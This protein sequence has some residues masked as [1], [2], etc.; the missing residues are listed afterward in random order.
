MS[1]IIN[2][3]LMWSKSGQPLRVFSTAC[4]RT[5]PADNRT[6]H[7][8]DRQHHCLNGDPRTMPTLSSFKLKPCTACSINKLVSR[9]FSSYPSPPEH[10]R[11]ASLRERKCAQMEHQLTA[12]RKT[13][14]VRMKQ[15][16]EDMSKYDTLKSMESMLLLRG[17]GGHL[18]DASRKERTVF[19]DRVWKMLK[20]KN[21]PLDASHYNALLNVYIDVDY[22]VDPL[23]FLETMKK[24]NVDPNRVTFQRLIYCYALMGKP[25]GA[26]KILESMREKNYPINESIFNS[27][28]YGN[29]KADRFE[30]AMSTYKL[31]TE[32]GMELSHETYKAF[33]SGY[34]CHID[35]EEVKQKFLETLEKMRSEDIDLSY[36][37]LTDI[38]VQLSLKSENPELVEKLTQ[39]CRKRAGYNQFMY[40]VIIKLIDRQKIEHAYH[41]M[42][43][44]DPTSNTEAY[45]LNGSFMVHYLVRFGTPYEK[46]VDICERM[47]SAKIN[48]W[49]F[50]KAAETAL[51]NCDRET[52]LK[53]LDLYESRSGLSRLHLAWPRICL[54]QNDDEIFGILK[55]K[56]LPFARLSPRNVK[57]TF[58]DFVWPKVQGNKMQFLK[59]CGKIGFDFEQTALTLPFELPPTDKLT[60]MDIFE[61]LHKVCDDPLKD[62]TSSLQ[63][64]GALC[65][66]Y[67]LKFTAQ[68]ARKFL[69]KIIENSPKEEALAQWTSCVEKY[70]LCICRSNMMERLIKEED[71]DSLQRVIDICSKHVSQRETLAN[72]AL[73]FLRCGK[74]K[75]VQRIFTR[76]G[77]FISDFALNRMM[78]TLL[79]AGEIDVMERLVSATKDLK[80]LNRESQ[81]RLLLQGYI[82]NNAVDKALDMWSAIQEEDLMPSLKV[83]GPLAVFL[84]ENGR[85]IP[86]EYKEEIL[87]AERSDKVQ[88]LKFEFHKSIRMN[89]I[90]EALKIK[91]ELKSMN[92]ELTLG[93]ECSIIE[94]L[95]KSEQI[96]KARGLIGDL[97]AKGRFPSPRIYQLLFQKMIAN[98]MVK[99]LDDMIDTLPAAL[100]Q[101]SW[102]TSM[103]VRA[104][105]SSSRED[106]E[107]CLKILPEFKP[108][109]VSALLTVLE[110]RPDAEKAIFEC[111][112]GMSSQSE[113]TLPK[114]IKWIHLMKRG[115]YSKAK[116]LFE[117]VPEWKNTLVV[118]PLLEVIKKGNV[119]MGL[120]LVEQLNQTNI[121]P[122]LKADIYDQIVQQLLDQ[123]KVLQ[124]EKLLNDGIKANIG[125]KNP[126]FVKYINQE[127]LSRLSSTIQQVAGRDLEL[128]LDLQEEV[129]KSNVDDKSS[130]Q[131]LSSD[132]EEEAHKA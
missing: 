110:A 41:L 1:R 29:L 69:R 24:D 74:D 105:Q 81:Y 116:E 94:Q 64:M 23:E 25:E 87:Q 42:L 32:H 22:P 77:F 122:T 111:L 119:E 83:L 121:N 73:A 50:S 14:M 9:N 16:I 58:H 92:L 86:F 85:Q 28:I 66:N 96:E 27:L 3:S 131:D 104:H 49:T 130:N 71:N 11:Y 115:D 51:Y 117:S 126:L 13:T 128:L 108:L 88:D 47:E 67:R 20:E 52:A 4:C 75:Q 123:D 56:V 120:K 34:A 125:N 36:H 37:D 15:F 78:E 39:Q 63:F 101:A 99:E 19:I 7:N 59:Q 43:T 57:E 70:Q 6:V 90:D 127:T 53:Y 31:M 106:L 107:R 89:R 40:R 95:L 10:H 84:K 114:N 54:A 80:Y 8:V 93:E 132:D 102:F 35:R 79:T 26:Q 21:A 103:F 33:L 112:E 12:E 55:D 38:I 109:P 76:P 17:C 44:M 68:S 97:M 91:E 61:L 46:V 60:E 48:E 5:N 30:N 82:Q 129:K 124:A 100:K 45:G 18:V 2:H 98:G 118:R 62:P 72:L 113:S 65:R